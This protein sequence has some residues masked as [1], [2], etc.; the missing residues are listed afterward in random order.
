MLADLHFLQPAWLLLIPPL[1]FAWFWRLG[2]M[3][4]W[5]ALLPPARL[6]FPPLA[7]M[8]TSQQRLPKP[9]YA[10][11][12]GG[13]FVAGLIVAVIGLAQPAVN[14]TT[15]ADTAKAEPV[16]LILL[17]G[18]A[19]TMNLRDYI[20]NGERV[21][22]MTMLKQLLADFVNHY[23]GRR[24]ALVVLG[25]PPA[26][27]LP[28]TQDKGVVLDAISRLRTALG[29]R[30]SDTGGAL[31]MI[32]EAF[33]GNDEKVVVLITDAGL[34]LGS[35]SPEDGAKLVKAKGMTL[36]TIAVGSADPAA[37]EDTTTGLLYE[38][39]NLQLMQQLAT[40]GGGRMYHALDTEHMQQ[41]LQEIETLH[42]HPAAPATTHQLVQP[43]YPWAIG[44]A[45]FLFLASMLLSR[46]P[47]TLPGSEK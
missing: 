25:D 39:V 41:A 16:D 5:P 32:A 31:K 40:I 28:L 7:N 45:I 18:T 9:S 11:R 33:S 6:R 17:V 42:R 34:Q 38:P 10:K 43:L 24:I 3:L 46:Q 13:F 35:L 36:H 22:R 12:A 19:V 47:A 1:L 23:A 26:L 21:S 2:G 29:G 37:A 14:T 15:A 27:W 4:N 8:T 44:T 30:L 20:A